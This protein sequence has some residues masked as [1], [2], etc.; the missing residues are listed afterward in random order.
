MTAQL[1]RI[2]LT[3][4]RLV[5][6]NIEA[7]MGQAILILRIVLFMLED[8]VQVL[9]SLVLVCSLQCFKEIIANYLQATNF[10]IPHQHK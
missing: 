4:R 6:T 5:R 8:R 1:P 7:M 2:P 3:G 9:F 10:M